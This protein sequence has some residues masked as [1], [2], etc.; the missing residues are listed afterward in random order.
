MEHYIA[1]L[2]SAVFFR[3]LLFAIA[4]SMDKEHLEKP[5]YGLLIFLAFIFI[6]IASVT[7][8]LMLALLVLHTGIPEQNTRGFSL[9]SALQYRN[10]CGFQ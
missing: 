4:F 1:P 6:D 5:V 9:V 7:V 2:Q 10:F 8:Y 3:V